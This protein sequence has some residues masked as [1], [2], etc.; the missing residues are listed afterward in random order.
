MAESAGMMCYTSINVRAKGDS[1]NAIYVILSSSRQNFPKYCIVVDAD[2][3]VFD[4]EVVNVGPLTRSQPKED[5]IILEGMRIPSSSDPSLVGPAPYSMS[6]MGIDAT[7]PL[8]SDKSR[9]RYS[10]APQIVG[11]K[12]PNP[13]SITSITKNIRELLEEKGPLFFYEI[14]KKFPGENFRNILLAWSELRDRRELEEGL[15]GR[16]SVGGK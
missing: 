12:S 1:R 7:I 2:I 16:F 8:D 10:R 14:S 4:D 3:D 11:R 15:D 6:K 13:K 9:F 5:T